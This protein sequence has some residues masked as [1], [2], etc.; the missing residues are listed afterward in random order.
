MMDIEEA[1]QA[2]TDIYYYFCF[3][4]YKIPRDMYPFALHGL[5]P[6][7]I[8]L[9]SLEYRFVYPFAFKLE[10]Q[11]IFHEPGHEEQA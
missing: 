11:L 7:K 5:V 9:E 6:G 2:F 8:Y 1:Y 10:A 3:S 4:Y